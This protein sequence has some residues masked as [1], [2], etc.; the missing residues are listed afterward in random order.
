PEEGYDS[1]TRTQHAPPAPIRRNDKAG[2]A[3]VAAMRVGEA[4]AIR[5]PAEEGV[6][7]VALAERGD[8]V[9]VD[10]GKLVRAVAACRDQEAA[11]DRRPG[12][13]HEAAW[14]CV[15][16]AHDL[17]CI[18]IVDYQFRIVTEPQHLAAVR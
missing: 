18:H 9:A 17:V 15:E 8:D 3:R 1:P 6:A 16:P 13:R 5:R 12:R 11:I 2:P 10:H 4:L 14:L 7:R